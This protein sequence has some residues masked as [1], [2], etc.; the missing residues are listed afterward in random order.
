M[1]LSQIEQPIHVK[2]NYLG[3]LKSN[4]V[5]QGVPRYEF[6]RRKRNSNYSAYRSVTSES[7][8]KNHSKTL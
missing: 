7:S 5:Q 8:T 6:L 3:L 4:K 2:R 1:P